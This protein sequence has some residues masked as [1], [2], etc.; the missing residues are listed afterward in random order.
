VSFFSEEKQFAVEKTVNRR[1]INAGIDFSAFTMFLSNVVE[2]QSSFS[3]LML[4]M[5][6]VM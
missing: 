4:C 3:L 5:A 1:G 2:I 6:E